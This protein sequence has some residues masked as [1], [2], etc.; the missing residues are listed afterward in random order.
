MSFRF[1][2]WPPQIH[3]NIYWITTLST[4]RL[5]GCYRWRCASSAAAADTVIGH[6]GHTNDRKI[7]IPTFCLC[8][9]S[10]FVL[11]TNTYKYYIIFSDHVITFI[12]LRIFCRFNFFFFLLHSSNGRFPSNTR[13]DEREQ[14]S[15]DAVSS[16]ACAPHI[17]IQFERQTDEKEALQVATAMW[18]CFG[19]RPKPGSHSQPIINIC[20]KC[21]LFAVNTNIE[22]CMA[23]PLE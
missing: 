23:C 2:W 16:L 17:D 22:R 7:P 9:L 19:G 3:T 6:T 14:S 15:L 8:R 20:I 12:E 4:F 5:R 18:V 10:P 1:C 13:T 21:K 11:A